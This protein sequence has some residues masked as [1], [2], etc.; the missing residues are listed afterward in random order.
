[1][2]FILRLILKITTRNNLLFL[3]NFKVHSTNFP[4]SNKIQICL[5]KTGILLINRFN[6]KPWPKDFNTLQLYFCQIS[7]ASC[8]FK[9][10]SIAFVDFCWFLLKISKFEVRFFNH[11]ICKSVRLWSLCLKVDFL[12]RKSIQ[13]RMQSQ[14]CRLPS[15]LIFEPL[16]HFNHCFY[17]NENLFRKFSKFD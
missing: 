4:S 8:C 3:N 11:A 1:M 10:I 16:I 6:Y 17:Q 9:F 12:S 7:S 5:S 2:S 15:P 13:D 14:Q